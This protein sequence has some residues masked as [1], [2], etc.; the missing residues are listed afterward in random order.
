MIFS[1]Q[2]MSPDPEKVRIIKE[3]PKTE[4]KAAVK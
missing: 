3:W 1:K 2:G 4:D